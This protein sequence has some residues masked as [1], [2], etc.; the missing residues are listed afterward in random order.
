MSPVEILVSY[1]DKDRQSL[2]NDGEVFPVASKVSWFFPS[3]ALV[4][5]STGLHDKNGKEIFEGDVLRRARNGA[6]YTFYIVVEFGN[7]VFFGITRPGFNHRLTAE[8]WGCCDKDGGGYDE[9][10]GNIHE[11]P[12][13]LSKQ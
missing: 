9:V 10:I 8:L 4:M 6:N 1:E 12:E 13:L 2:G 3:Q 7:G 11:N 5:Q